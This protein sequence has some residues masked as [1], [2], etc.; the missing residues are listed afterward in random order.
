MKIMI[1]NYI[2]IS[3]L[4]FSPHAVVI[5]KDNKISTIDLEPDALCCTD[6]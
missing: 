1:K 2:H 5:V 6:L 4:S 3:I